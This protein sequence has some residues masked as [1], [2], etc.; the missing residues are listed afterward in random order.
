MTILRFII[1]SPFPFCDFC[2]KR[3]VPH[4]LSSLYYSLN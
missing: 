4:K 2:G 3:L 1:K